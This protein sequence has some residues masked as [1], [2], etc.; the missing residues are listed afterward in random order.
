M[1]PGCPGKFSPAEDIFSEFVPEGIHCFVQLQFLFVLLR[2]HPGE[3]IKLLIRLLRK[4]GHLHT[5]LAHMPD[6]SRAKLAET[7]ERIINEGSGGLICI[8]L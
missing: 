4:P 3:Q 1:G 8:I 5:K 7:L 6:E 2:T